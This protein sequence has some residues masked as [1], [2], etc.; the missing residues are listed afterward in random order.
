MP[1]AAHP[2]ASLGSPEDPSLPPAILPEVGL[3]LLG[4]CTVLVKAQTDPGC[5]P[6]ARRTGPGLC[7]QRVLAGAGK[8]WP[9][10]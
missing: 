7:L 2:P 5:R 4:A 8:Q 9:L 6:S 3:L 10:R 1:R